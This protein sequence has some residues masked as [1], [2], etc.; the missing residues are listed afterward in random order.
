M[1]GERERCVRVYGDRHAVS[2]IRKSSAY[3][4]ATRAGECLGFFTAD[5]LLHTSQS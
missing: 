2:S 5:T 1:G 4:E 3:T